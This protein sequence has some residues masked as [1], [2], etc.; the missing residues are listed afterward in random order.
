MPEIDYPFRS[1]PTI[2][3]SPIYRLLL[4]GFNCTTQ[5]VHFNIVLN[6]F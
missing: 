3:E 6:S 5:L 1:A 4:L 2:L